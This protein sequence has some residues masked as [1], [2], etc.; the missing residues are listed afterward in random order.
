[1]SKSENIKNYY[2]KKHI[3]KK[4]LE[5]KLNAKNIR[6]NKENS[7][8]NRLWENLISRINKA[9]KNKNITRTI[10]YKRL[11]GCNERELYLHLIKSL[12]E[13]LTIYDYG[14]WEIDHIKPII[15]FD[16]TNEKEQ[17]ECFNYI[18]LR[19]LETSINR[20]KLQLKL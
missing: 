18:N 12:P 14:K 15:L 7:L 8:E 16:L 11:I 13:N 17:L 19:P 2:I 9:Y 4:K 20:Q 6:I 3:E 10:S 1:M 5:C